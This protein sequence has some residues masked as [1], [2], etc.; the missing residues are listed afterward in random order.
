M[1]TD[2]KVRRQTCRKEVNTNKGRQVVRGDK[3]SRVVTK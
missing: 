3:D 1:R 2:K